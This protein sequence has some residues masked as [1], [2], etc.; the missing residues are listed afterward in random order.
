MLE[1][2]GSMLLPRRPWQPL[3]HLLAVLSMTATVASTKEGQ[4]V[5]LGE[6]KAE[7]ELNWILKLLIAALCVVPAIMCFWQVAE[8]PDVAD[9]PPVQIST[10]DKGVQTRD[11]AP[12]PPAG[13][14]EVRSIGVSVEPQFAWY[15]TDELW[16]MGARAPGTLQAERT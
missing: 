5:V 12:P 10:I 8:Q 7:N 15:T 11:S 4:L 16:Q 13:R 3:Q 2:A 6:E 1:F 14:V 9:A